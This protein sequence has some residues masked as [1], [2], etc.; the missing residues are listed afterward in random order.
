VWQINASSTLTQNISSKHRRNWDPSLRFGSPDSSI[1]CSGLVDHLS[2]TRRSPVWDSSI[3]C[4]R[5]VDRPIKSLIKK[6]NRAREGRI[7]RFRKSPSAFGGSEISRINMLESAAVGSSVLLSFGR[8]PNHERQSSS[9]SCQSSRP[10]WAGSGR[11]VLGR[12][13]RGSGR[14]A[15]MC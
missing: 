3:T 15:G 5:L 12:S 2:G 10:R 8:R 1:T 11:P 13:P 14:S 9:V 4:L 7:E 6:P